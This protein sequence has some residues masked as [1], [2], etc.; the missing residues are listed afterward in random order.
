QAFFGMAER[1][2]AKGSSANGIAVDEE[3]NAYLVG[4]TNTGA[5]DTEG[6]QKQCVGFDNPIDD[7]PSDDGFVV[8]LNAAGSAL[9]GGTLLGGLASDVATSVALDGERNVYVTGTTFSSD[10]PTKTAWQIQKQGAENVADGFL[11]KLAPLA[12]TLS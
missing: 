9:I 10:F 8:V 1:G 12:T 6:F 11:V 4:T 2:F 5:F 7:C 3:G